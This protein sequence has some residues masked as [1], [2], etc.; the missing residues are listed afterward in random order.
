MTK[1]LKIQLT[2]EQTESKTK[3]KH[4]QKQ[5]H[6]ENGVAVNTRERVLA[7]SDLSQLYEQRV[8]EISR[9]GLESEWSARF[10]LIYILSGASHSTLYTNH[11]GV[12]RP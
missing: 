7:A 6:K 11:T 4:L 10:A 12:L 2:Q 3:M 1:D 5:E 9:S 8:R